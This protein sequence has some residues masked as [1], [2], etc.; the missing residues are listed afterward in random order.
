VNATARACDARQNEW[1]T[2][3]M[4]CS[5]SKVLM[6]NTNSVVFCIIYWMQYCNTVSIH[7]VLHI[8]LHIKMYWSPT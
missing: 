1:M 2:K 3:L 5:L 8:K 6:P 4:N 7:N